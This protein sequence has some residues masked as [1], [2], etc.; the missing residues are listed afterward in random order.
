MPVSGIVNK[1]CTIYLC[2]GAIIDPDILLKEIQ[3]NDIHSDRLYIHPRAA[4]INSEDI[5]NEKRS[6]GVKQI[7]STMSGVGSALVRKINRKAQL[8][9]DCEKLQSFIQDININRLLDEGCTAFMEVPQGIDLS[10]N[11]GFAY[12]YC[13]SRDITPASAM[14]DAGVHPRYIGNISVSIRTFPIRVGNVVENGK[15]VGFSG[16]FYP[17][18]KETSWKKLKLKTEF[19]TRTNRVRRVASFSFMQYAKMLNVMQPDHIFLNFCNYL[20]RK[21]L[22]SLLYQLREVTHLGFGPTIHDIREFG[23]KVK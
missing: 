16:P 9:S 17:D 21:Q 12:P 7:A 20:S 19:T 1:R 11:H 23:D 6:D 4:V 3:E 13:T 18:S 15:E 2:A 14:N 22:E 10:I 8:A 5:L